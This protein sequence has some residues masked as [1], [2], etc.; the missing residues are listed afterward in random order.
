MADGGSFVRNV[1]AVRSTWLHLIIIIFRH[2]QE[3]QLH[4][5]TNWSAC[6]EGIFTLKTDDDESINQDKARTVRSDFVILICK[7][8]KLSLQTAIQDDQSVDKVGP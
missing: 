4:R 5:L 6:L 7:G 1:L 2:Q 8:N 3:D